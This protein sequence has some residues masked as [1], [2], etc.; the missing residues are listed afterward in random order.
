MGI[1]NIREEMSK[2]N[3]NP[4]TRLKAHGSKLKAYFKKIFPQKR[5]FKIMCVFYTIIPAW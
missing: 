2:K 3:F 4:K 5:F 1:P